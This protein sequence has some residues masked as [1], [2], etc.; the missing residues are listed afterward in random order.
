MIN[1]I[2]KKLGRLKNK[3]FSGIFYL[4]GILLVMISLVVISYQ[5]FFYLY[6]GAWTSMQ[7]R[8]FL[9][10]APYQFYTWILNPESWLG[11]HKAVTW[12][13]AVPLAFACFVTGYLLI[14][15]SD[16]MALFSD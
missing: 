2:F 16:F 7:L 3:F 10:Y 13:L 14:K 4:T 15:I 12:L 9:E 5:V 1:N 6:N 11:L 8:V